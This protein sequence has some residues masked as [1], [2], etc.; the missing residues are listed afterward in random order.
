MTI[1]EVAQALQMSTRA[2]ERQWTM[3]RAWLRR[4]LSEVIA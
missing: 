2:V 1:D 4:E 3:I